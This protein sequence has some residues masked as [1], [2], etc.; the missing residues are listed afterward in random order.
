MNNKLY[1]ITMSFEQ[2]KH[3]EQALK[4]HTMHLIEEYFDSDQKKVPEEV[5]IVND[6]YFVIKE[7]TDSEFSFEAPMSKTQELVW[8]REID[9][10]EQCD[11]EDKPWFGDVWG[12]NIL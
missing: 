10:D 12:K 3:L 6:M 8:I 2:L 1:E 4:C 7:H 11:N 5:N 9:L